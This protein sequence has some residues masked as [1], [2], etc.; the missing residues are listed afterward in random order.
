MFGILVLNWVRCKVHDTDI[1]TI[2]IVVRDKGQDGLSKRLHSHST[3]T[4]FATPSFNAGMGDN[5]CYS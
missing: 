1:I 4:T 3:S 2:Q 5:I